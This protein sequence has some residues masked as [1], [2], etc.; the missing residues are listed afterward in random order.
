[1]SICIVFLGTGAAVPTAQRGLPAVMLQRGKE[2]LMFDCGE[3]VQRQMMLAKLGF[4]KKLAIFITH[5]HGDHVL[6]LP[7][8]LQ[9]MALMNREK[10]VQVYG[11]VGLAHF[12]DCLRVTLQFQ[13]TFQVDVH[14]V[15]AA[16]MV[17][18]G[19]EYS[20]SALPSNHAV[21]SFA[22]GFLEKP[23]PGKFHPEKARAQG[24]PKGEAWGQ[25]QRGKNYVFPNGRTVKPQDVAN[26][27]RKGRKII[28]TG[29]TKPFVG[30]EVFAEDADLVIHEATFDD[31][32]MERAELDTHSTPS[33]AATQAKK[34][35]A[36]S[37]VLTHISARYPD[38]ALLLNQAKKVFPNTVIAEDFLELKL[39]LGE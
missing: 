18:D 7:G 24:V 3:G 26:S 34:A 35:N 37:L 27:P 19:E 31:S 1:M 22:Y 36:K 8:L 30:F 21:T 11:P 15:S 10:P 16:G 6:G 9:T 29:D 14:E 17:C 5:M 39:P 2:Q 12:L 4:Q 13:L 20:V 38:T 23:R 25:L 33:Q 28:Y 32:L